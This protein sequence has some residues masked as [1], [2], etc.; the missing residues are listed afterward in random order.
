MKKNIIILAIIACIGLAI[1]LFVYNSTNKINQKNSNNTFDVPQEDANYAENFLNEYVNSV[2]NKNDDFG[3]NML[4]EST[5]N[6]F[7]NDAKKYSEK[8]EYIRTVLNSH[9]KERTITKIEMLENSFINENEAIKEVINCNITSTIYEYIEYT[10]LDYYKE[11]SWFKNLE[12][13]EYESKKYKISFDEIE[14]E[15]VEWEVMKK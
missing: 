6:I 7:Q 2:L 4:D 11:Y 8:M 15:D 12:L 9:I 13:K 14:K 1:Y 5:K 10:A 3:F